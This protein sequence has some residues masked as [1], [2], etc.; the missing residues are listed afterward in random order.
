MA[1]KGKFNRMKKKT[2][3]VILGLLRDETMTGYEIKNCIDLRMSFFWQESYGQIYPELNAMQNEGLLEA[4]E[5]HESG[6]RV[7]FSYSITEKGRQ[8]FNEWMA[9]ACEKDTIR[10]EALLKFFLADD[11]NQSDVI[12]HLEKFYDQNRER[13]QCYEMFQNSLK[14][15]EAVHNHKYILQMLDLGI[16]QQK[17]YCE[18]SSSYIIELKNND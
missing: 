4:Q 1:L 2:R 12:H 16:R 15:F 18:W 10:S 3:Y 5:D 13:L 7:K 8:V 6:K 9:Q 17:L 11:H 14:G